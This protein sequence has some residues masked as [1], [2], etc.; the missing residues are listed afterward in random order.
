MGSDDSFSTRS[1]HDATAPRSVNPPAVG[2]IEQSAGWTFADLDEVDDVY[3]GLRRGAIYGGSGVPNHWALEAALCSLHG[4]VETLITAA[5]MSAMAAAFFTCL[6]HGDTVVVSRD[7]Y[8]STARLL[9]DF[10]RFG[11]RSVFADVYD[12]AAL[13]KTLS[14][15]A[16]LLVVET[17]S[18]PRARVIDVAALAAAAHEHTAL[19][20]VDNSLASPY[21]CQPLRLGADIVMESLTKFIGGHHD[22]MLGAL[23]GR[24][25]LIEPARSFAARC[26]LIGSA[27]DCWLACRSLATLELRLS[28]SSSNALAVASWLA[29]QAAVKATHY[30]GLPADPSYAAADATLSRGFGSIVSFELADDRAAVDRFLAHLRLIKLVLSF[31]GVATTVSHPVTSS[32]RSLSQDER[33][34]VGLHDGFLRLS[35]GV[36]DPADIIRDLKCGLAAV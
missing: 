2:G 25:E 14:A 24:R 8:S 29:T 17:I 5:G 9:A 10:A 26:G 28:R 20:L 18:N 19:L 13:T 22:L 7:L 23:C 15:G 1:I 27:F 21:H 34:A 16:R 36:E 4:A 32:H 30:S 6:R 31:G 11:V 33:A 3:E 35:V 12:P